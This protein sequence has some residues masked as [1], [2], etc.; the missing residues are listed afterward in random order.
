MPDNKLVSVTYKKLVSDIAELFEG[1]RKSLV[2]AC[3]KTGQWIVEVEQE[4]R[5]KAAHGSGLLRKLSKDLTKRLGSG[6]SVESLRRMRRFYLNDPKQSA[7]TVLSWAHCI[8][9]L[10]IENPALRAKLEKHALEEGLTHKA[11]RKLVRHE[12][13]REQVAKNLTKG[14]GSFF[15]VG[16]RCLTPF[17]PDLLPV[18][19]LG[20]LNTYLIKDP[21]DTAW[22]DKK[23]L[24]LDHGFKGYRALT[25]EESRGPNT[26]QSKRSGDWGRPNYRYGKEIKSLGGLKA[27]DVVEWTGTKIK[28]T[29]YSVRRTPNELLYTYKAYLETVIDGDTL[30]VALDIGMRELSRQKLRLRG[31][32]CPEIDTKEGQMAKK[33]VETVLHDVSSL[34]VLSSRNITYDRYEA[35][36]FLPARGIKIPA[37][38]TGPMRDQCFL[39][40]KRQQVYLNNLLLEKGFAVRIYK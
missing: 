32:D 26:N 31:I 2:E 36:V 20:L 22:P 38:G 21:N 23:V 5:L 7:P 14:S 30:W 40:A 6:F 13:V 10:P 29:P 19:K 12:L 37:A 16:K 9:V 4:G 17:A 11:L 35:D 34:T 25:P 24:L 15:A 3:W 8:E 1:V 33:F 18:P 27:G 39:D 28:K